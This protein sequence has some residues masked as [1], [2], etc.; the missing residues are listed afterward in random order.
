MFKLIPGRAD[1]ITICRWMNWS[2]ADF[3]WFEDITELEPWLSEII[4]MMKAES[5]AVLSNK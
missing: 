4:S 1:I 5:K 3:D 2:L